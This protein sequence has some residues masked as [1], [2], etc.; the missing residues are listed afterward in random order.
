MAQQRYGRHQALVLNLRAA[1]RLRENNGL[2]AELAKRALQQAE[3]ELHELEKT[4]GGR[5]E[6]RKKPKVNSADTCSI[7]IDE[8]GAHSLTA[9]ED[10]GAFCL[11]AV[12]V[13]DADLDVFEAKWKRWKLTH[14]GSESR[15]VHEPNVRRRNGPFYKKRADTIEALSQILDELDYVA[16]VCVLHREKYVQK[17]G[18]KAMDESLPQHGYLMTLHFMAERLAL[19]LQTQFGGAKARVIFEARGPL[20]DAQMQYEFARLFLDG[21]AYL[22]P[23]YFRRQFLPGLTFNSKNDN[24]PGLE[25]ADL[26]ARPCGEKVLDPASKPERWEQARAKLCPGTETK[27]SILGL[28]IT[29][30]DDAYIDLWKS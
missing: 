11:A 20:E 14:L 2:D 24:V 25:I 23:G 16:V 15:K 17:H 13:R 26:I 10:F 22:D 19:A 6:H 7:Y 12:I 21:T 3:D 28:K 27:H 4:I 29:P 8:C 5:I 30:W 18:T 9:K 1:V